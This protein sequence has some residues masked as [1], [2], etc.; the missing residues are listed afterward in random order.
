[1]GNGKKSSL[2]D[3][4]RYIKSVSVYI[5]FEMSVGNDKYL[6][7]GVRSVELRINV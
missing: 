1:M 5:K 4:V 6:A 7:I 3:W 2:G